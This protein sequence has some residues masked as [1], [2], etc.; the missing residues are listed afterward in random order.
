M[1]VLQR[2]CD[3]TV[4]GHIVLERLSAWKMTCTVKYRNIIAQNL[5]YGDKTNYDENDV[6]RPDTW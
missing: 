2:M 1:N 6:R 4:H 5:Y 3:K